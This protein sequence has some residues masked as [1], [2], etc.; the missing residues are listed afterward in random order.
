MQCRDAAGED[1]QEED[2]LDSHPIEKYDGILF[3]IDPF[4][5]E[6]VRAG[7][8]GEV[9]VAAGFRRHRAHSG[10]PCGP[11]SDGHHGYS[12]R[13]DLRG[14]RYSNQSYTSSPGNTGNGVQNST[15]RSEY[16]LLGSEL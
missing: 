8:V 6:G 9:D 5:E 1:F 11:H 12:E 10:R 2:R 3:V 16:P 4:A 13:G 7:L 14:A 15:R